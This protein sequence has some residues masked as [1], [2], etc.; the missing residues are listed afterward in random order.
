MS[1]QPL[2]YKQYCAIIARWPI[3][4]LRPSL[5][6]STALRARVTHYF[7]THADPDS[8]LPS[9]NT[10]AV[11]APSTPHPQAEKFDAVTVKREINALAGL[12]EDRFM[13]QYPLA[14]NMLKP[15]GNPDYYDKLMR[16]LD[17]APE[18]SWLGTKM[19][20]WKGWIRVE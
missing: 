10:N 12:L 11:T 14:E 1:L 3:D 4:P 13:K 17:A 18:R 16:E 7:G 5:N 2:L 20:A 15:K 6:F 19:N 8:T 9:Q